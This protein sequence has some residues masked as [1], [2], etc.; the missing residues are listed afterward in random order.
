MPLIDD[1]GRLFGKVNLIDAL[2]VLF[3]LGVIPLVYGA[4]LLFK[5]PVPVIDSL[6]PAQVV[7]KTEV[8]IRVEGHDLRPFLFARIG[9]RE[10]RG[11]LV[12][13]P[14][15][16]EIKLPLDMEPGTYDVALFDQAQELTRKAGAITILR[17]PPR[18][19][20]RLPRLDVQ[21]LGHFVGIN[22]RSRT[23]FA[24]ATTFEPPRVEGGAAAPVEPPLGEVLAVRDPERGTERLRV[25]DNV[26]INAPATQDWH[27]P[28]ILRLNCA[29]TGNE[30]RI[31]DV[32]VAQ[33]AVITLPLNR[34][35]TAE[36]VPPA[37]TAGAAATVAEQVRFVISEIR[38]P[39]ARLEFPTI[40]SATATVRVRF[41]APP[42][43]ADLMKAGD[44]DLL[45]PPA[46]PDGERAVLT[47][48]S[49]D[50]QVVTATNQIDAVMRRNLGVQQQVTLFNGSVRVPVTFTPL[51]WTY[52]ERAVKVGAPFYFETTAGG[53]AGWI[54]E[55][56]VSRETRRF[57]P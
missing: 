9:D 45:V 51:G 49:S 18:P 27:V 2:V 31:G 20:S 14:R 1:Q 13:T 30:C 57:A 35:R 12:Q 17:T 36:D 44:V 43:V 37:G 7:E 15:I 26:F 5:T 28:A 50:R 24:V 54:V 3:V 25:G 4:F 11:F 47:E 42:E 38:Q 39:D 46:A 48:V 29:I 23:L 21:A 41:V 33:R 32:A 52:K 19:V 56:S 55:L 34:A 22:D 53:M 40:R 8:A 16:G 6:T 10:A